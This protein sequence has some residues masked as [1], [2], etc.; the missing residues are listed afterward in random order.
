MTVNQ[1]ATIVNAAQQQIVGEGA[2][3]TV[4]LEGLI[5]MGNRP[6]MQL[7]TTTMSKPSS[8]TSAKLCSSTEPIRGLPR[9]F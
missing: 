6:S 1:V 4:D 7:P 9:P 3:Q 2:I 5:D 8:I